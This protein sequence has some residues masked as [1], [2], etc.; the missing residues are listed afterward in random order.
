MSIL[1]LAVRCILLEWQ[2]PLTLSPLPV[3]SSTKGLWIDPVTLI[4]LLNGWE[5]AQWALQSSRR[6]QF[7][8]LP[9]PR[10]PGAPEI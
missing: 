3:R 10:G 1:Q 5:L 9:K 4:D 7:W 8:S 2:M 6:L